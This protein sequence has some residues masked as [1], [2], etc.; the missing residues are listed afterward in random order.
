MKNF[1]CAWPW[2]E[3]VHRLARP[4]HDPYEGGYLTGPGLSGYPRAPPEGGWM[5]AAGSRRTGGESSVK[6]VGVG[7]KSFAVCA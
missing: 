6:Y 4:N 3:G 2:V 1:F 7:I 5:I